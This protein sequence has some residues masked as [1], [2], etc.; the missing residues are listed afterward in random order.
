MRRV[1]AGMDLVGIPEP[2]AEAKLAKINGLLKRPNGENAAKASKRAENC[3]KALK[4]RRE[5]TGRYDDKSKP[6]RCEK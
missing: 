3:R 2:T 5:Q 6:Q 1:E 4:M